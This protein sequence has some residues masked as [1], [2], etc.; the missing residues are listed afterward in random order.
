MNKSRLVLA[1]LYNDKNLGDPIIAYSTEWLIT[2]NLPQKENIIHLSL[3][4]Q[5]PFMYRAYAYLKRKL[6]LSTREME[7]RRKLSHYYKR[8]IQPHDFIIFVGGGLI[9]YKYQDFHIAISE[10][11]KVAEQKKAKVVFN[12][13][14]VEGYDE[15]SPQCQ[16]LKQAIQQA[17]RSKTLIYFTTRDDIDTL[18]TKYLDNTPSIPCMR[19]ADPAVWCADAYNIAPKKNNN[20]IGIGIIREHI[21]I[22]NDIPYTTDQLTQLYINIIKELI[23][24][25][26]KISLFTNGQAHDNVFALQIQKMLQ[27]QNIHCNLQ[28]PQTPHELINMISQ[29]KGIISARLHSCIIAYSL[30]IPAIGL[31][32][33]DKLTLFG[34]NIEAEDYFISHDKFSAEYII[35]QFRQAL[36]HKY[37][38]ATKVQF[39]QTIKDS[40]KDIAKLYISHQQ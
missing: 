24:Q 30:G 9:K 19:V 20:S 17:L 33:N 40:I 1:G 5:Q 29:Y 8:Q 36:A 35:Q 31:V 28:I 12:S 32:W 10:L 23:H 11:L 4:P 37:P 14:G 39:R 15:N 7:L 38:E 3:F 6:G 26:E 2:N 27:E 16:M 13:L 21:F 25:K 22:D 34:K 18:K